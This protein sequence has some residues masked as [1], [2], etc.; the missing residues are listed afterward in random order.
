M[1]SI[2]GKK[3]RELLLSMK[4]IEIIFEPVRIETTEKKANLEQLIGLAD[5]LAHL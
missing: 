4:N 1:G 2:A 3:V 5:L